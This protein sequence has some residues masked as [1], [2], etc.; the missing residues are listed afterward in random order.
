MVA[1]EY[2]KQC[3]QCHKSGDQMFARI[4]PMPVNGKFIRV[5]NI[6]W[7]VLTVMKEDGSLH[8]IRADYYQWHGVDDEIVLDGKFS[9][10]QLESIIAYIKNNLTN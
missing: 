3:Q 6:C 5:C 9:I 4:Y 10:A 1:K 2:G 8:S 7:D